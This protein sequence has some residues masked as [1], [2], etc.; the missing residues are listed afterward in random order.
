MGK[1]FLVVDTTGKADH[2]EEA[3]AHLG[4]LDVRIEPLRW[5]TE[6]EL[7]AGC[8]DADLILVTGA[9]ITR[10]VLQALPKLRA[11]VRYGV[12]LDR[13]DLA[14]AEELGVV[15]ANTR[16]FCTSEMADH[17]LGLILACARGIVNDAVGVRAGGYGRDR[18]SR[19]LRLAGGTAGIIGFGA[20]GQALARRLQ[21]MEMTVIACDP[22]ADAAQ[23][24]A[25]DVRLVELG[26]LLRE[27][28]V[29]SVHCSLTD[30]TRGLIGAGELAMM[31]DTAIIVNTAR[32]GIIDET[33]LAGALDAGEIMAAGLDVLEQEPP[34]PDHP[35]RAD[36]RCIITSHNAWYSEQAA[37]EVYVKAFEQVGRI[38]RG[39]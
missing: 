19:V 9:Y 22:Y 24:R 34:P 30:E 17:A 13:I 38:L 16:G 10:E 35:L 12:G 3:L 11:V 27:A 26:E 1:S 2:S 36:P 23:A 29:V 8:R 4:G 14:A 21:A 7:I 6:Q 28:D 37:R 25:M 39:L 15:V 20:V 18:S 32:G 33:A 5:E 31:K